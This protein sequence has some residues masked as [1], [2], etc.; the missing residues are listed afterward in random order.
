MHY[1][2]IAKYYPYHIVVF[3]IDIIV[4]VN[5]FLKIIIIIIIIVAVV[6]VV[7]VVGSEKPG[8]WHLAPWYPRTVVLAP[9]KSGIA[10]ET[11]LH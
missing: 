11:M 3:V 1:F 10:Q 7:V 2:F 9:L 4:I 5:L 8:T 6:V